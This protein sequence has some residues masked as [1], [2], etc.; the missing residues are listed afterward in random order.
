MG[1]FKKATK[2]KSKLRLALVGPSGS[3]KTF[4]ALTIASAMGG[5]VAVIDSEHGSASKYADRFDFDVCELAEFSPLSYINAMKDA[6]EYDV[7]II[8]SLSHAWMGKGGTLEMV[9]RKARQMQSANSFT[10]W[11]DVTPLHNQLV[12]ALLRFPGHLI[13][14]MRAKTEYVMETNDKGKS[15][16]KKIGLAPVQRD[17]LEYEFDV[18][19]DMTLDNDMLVGKSRCPELHGQVINK[20]GA[21]VAETLKGWLNSGV[22]A[23]PR[24]DRDHLIAQT[25]QEMM[26][27]GW[28]AKDGKNH[29]EQNYGVK[30]RAHLSDEQLVDFARYIE[31]LPTTTHL[32]AS[33]EAEV[34]A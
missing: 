19:A 26:R 15:V 33:V 24:I 6:S 7:L 22:A 8:D 11:R 34:T 14:T 21:E 5:T 27:L 32:P 1:S 31:S 29:L 20:P 30:S 3:G 12:E 17:G 16:P 13:V 4:T 2:E 28:N 25:E 23:K 9:D 18:T 10:A